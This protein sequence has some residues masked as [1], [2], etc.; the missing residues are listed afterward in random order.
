[1]TQSPRIVTPW[2]TEHFT[3]N[4][5]VQVPNIEGLWSPIPLRVWFLEPESLTIGYH[6]LQDSQ[7][8]FAVQSLQ[9]PCAAF[10]GSIAC[11]NCLVLQVLTAANALACSIG[12]FKNTTQLAR[13]GCGQC[14]QR[15]CC[16]RHAQPAQPPQ[17]NKLPDHVRLHHHAQTS[18]NS[19]ACYEPKSNDKDP[20]KAKHPSRNNS[21]QIVSG[22]E[23]CLTGQPVGCPTRNKDMLQ[24]QNR[25]PIKGKPNNSSIHMLPKPIWCLKHSSDNRTASQVPPQYWQLL[26]Y[27]YW[28]VETQTSRAPK[29]G[30]GIR[31]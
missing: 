15:N 11:S 4:Q 30:F 26:A 31:N 24:L 9:I 28:T 17:Q 20:Q 3:A 5:R 2:Q 7:N 8:N 6:A 25:K 13:T 22:S 19:W 21:R 16:Q 23:A 14:K 1:M 18:A 12:G 27:G 29:H 10:Q